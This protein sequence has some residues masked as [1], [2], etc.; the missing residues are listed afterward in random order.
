MEPATLQN[1]SSVAS[2]TSTFEY[3]YAA[4]SKEIKAGNVDWYIEEKF[5]G[6]LLV[7]V[8]NELV[9]ELTFG[10]NNARTFEKKCHAKSYF[11]AKQL[12]KKY[13]RIIAITK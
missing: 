8:K 7:N 6:A 1:S 4:T 9:S 2:H 12:K 5:T 3:R 13:F 10:C 11:K